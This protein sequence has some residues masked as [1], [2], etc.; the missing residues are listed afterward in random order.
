MSNTESK[1]DFLEQFVEKLLVRSVILFGIVFL[2]MYLL[3][4]R[5]AFWVPDSAI[6]AN[7][8][9]VMR[10][11][12]PYV[13]ALMRTISASESNVRNPYAVLYG[14]DYA[15]DLSKHPDLCVTI[16]AGP[17]TGN[18]TTAAGRYQFITS[19]WLEEARHYHPDPPTLLFWQGYSFSPEYQ[20]Q[21]VYRWLNDSQAWGVDL[22]Q[23]LKK[24]QISTVLQ[25]LS[26]TWTSLG[27]GIEDNANTSDLPKIYRQVLKEELGQAAKL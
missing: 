5:P 26:G 6:G 19:T 3:D 14:G 8:P 21:V 2:M 25:R 12:D 18:C 11:G 15:A 23:L 10:G 4:K 22:R 9:L 24:G 20:D 16:V 17:N 27:Y 7:T 13:R 1:P